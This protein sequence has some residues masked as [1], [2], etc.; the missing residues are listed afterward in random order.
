MGA[1]PISWGHFG[2][3]GSPGW[4]SG[5]AV[6]G[7]LLGDSAEEREEPGEVV[8][9]HPQ[10]CVGLC[11]IRG[12]RTRPLLTEHPPCAMYFHVYPFSRL[13]A[14]EEDGGEIP[15]SKH[16]TMRGEPRRKL[17]R[18]KTELCLLI[19]SSKPSYIDEKVLL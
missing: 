3:E 1:T 19:R 13:S 8:E 18:A 15:S 10:L 14:G 16:D 6:L 17:V 2:L 5:G 11:G 12:V 9:G 7:T 4:G